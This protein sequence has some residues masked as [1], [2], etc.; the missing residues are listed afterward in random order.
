MTDA[1]DPITL[2]LSA[3]SLADRLLVSALVDRLAGAASAPTTGE[4]DLST[5]DWMEGSIAMRRWGASED[6]LERWRIANKVIAKKVV[7]RWYYNRKYPP[8]TAQTSVEAYHKNSNG[9]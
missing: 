3:L 1:P 7:G 2:K 5:G 9:L 4:L 8:I 6:T